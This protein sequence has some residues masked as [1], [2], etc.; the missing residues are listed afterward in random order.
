MPFSS[1]RICTVF[2]LMG[3][4]GFA[5]AV[6][7]APRK[8]RRQENAPE[9]R[10]QILE[11]Q[12]ADPTLSPGE[13]ARLCLELA[14]N[15][16]RLKDFADEAEVLEDALAAGITNATL[17]ADAHY[18]LGRT[19]EALGEP[20]QAVDQFDTVWQQYPDS[21]HHL[22][23]AME[24]GDL[25]LLASNTETATEWYETIVDQQ[26]RSKLAFLARDK[27]L[28]MTNGVSAVEITDESHRPVYLNQQFRRLDQYLYSQ[29]YDKAGALAQ[30]LTATATN[31]QE[32]AA[33]SYQLAHHYWMYGH[34]EGAGAFVANALQTTGDRHVKALILAGHVTRSLGQTEAA[35]GYYQQAITLA[36]SKEMTIT[37][38]QQSTRLLCKSG[39]DSAAQAVAA[40]GKQ[41]F[42]GKPQL[43]AYLDRMAN[44][45]RD[46]ANPQWTNYAAQ[47]AATATNEV[48]RR[49]LMQLANNARLRGDLTGAR[50][51]YQR[52]VAR[53]GKEWRSNADMQLRLLDVQ[54]QQ[55]N[56]VA[57][58]IAEAAFL[59]SETNAPDTVRAYKLYRLGKVLASNGQT[60]NAATRWQQVLSQYP[61]SG[62]R[63][64]A[65]VQLAQLY[66][67]TGD[68]TNAVTMYQTYVQ[69]PETA[70]RF[71][72]RAYAD[73]I[74]LKRALGDPI[75]AGSLLDNAK[76]L[77][78][79]TKDAELQ[80]NLAQY[81]LH[82]SHTNVA[83]QLL[84]MGITNAEAAI[85]VEKDPQKRL[86]WEYLIVR[87]LDDFQQYARLGD[88][89][90]TIDLS[91]L[92]N[93]LLDRTMRFA[94]YCYL[95]RGMERSGRWPKAE[96]LCQQV[97]QTIP[98][99]SVR[100]GHVLYRL[101]QQ[102]R[103]RGETNLVYQF[104]EEAFREVPTSYIS[105]HMYLHLAMDDFN[106]GRYTNAL[107]RIAQLEEAVPVSR[108]FSPGWAASYRWDCQYVKG[109]CLKAMGNATAG[110][111][112]IVEA[113]MR[114]SSV[115]QSYNLLQPA[116]PGKP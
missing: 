27:L 5:A 9:I 93:P 3:L 24:L 97:I 57:A 116:T 28:A 48:G 42:T 25:S 102:A 69:N 4:V 86:W 98:E 21:H 62:F 110:Q 65:Q 18:Y 109:H 74:R 51:F 115:A 13:R 108:V 14:S 32:R 75:S 12:L 40:A 87:R 96:A 83:S 101:S 22:N 7:A 36:P 113:V 63:S 23:A 81:F 44:T 10:V 31:T 70:P 34:V 84:E 56:R 38:Y 52:L 19:Y 29:L 61:S 95:M 103:N 47:V 85:R 45:L 76:T 17:A 2:L 15:D 66:E 43:A 79:Q 112:L 99:D 46:R 35:L 30:Q 58:A 41:A 59:G 39:H 78:L 91:L 105:Q 16:Y 11:Q 50:Q 89:A 104:A 114:K 94:T 106:A 68:L 111:K 100:L 73:L 92:Q 82:S 37:A 77:A 90:A 6:S 80:L 33:L 8:P 26:P 49:A 55:T 72:L 20:E 64:L 53:P 1:R 71:K 60:A 54:L 88:R 107:N 67:S